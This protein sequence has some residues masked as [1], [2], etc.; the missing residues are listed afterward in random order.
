MI[1]SI[2]LIVSIIVIKFLLDRRLKK[3][4]FN[5]ESTRKKHSELL[6]EYEK[7]N[8]INGKLSQGMQSL[9]ELYEITKE[10]TKHLTFNEVLAVFQERLKKDI[11]LEDCRFLNP[12]R[13]VIQEKGGAEISNGVKPEIDSASLPGY[14][15]FHLKIA[16]D[17]M[18]SF[19]LKGLK[20]EEREKF[21]ILFNQLL[22]V[23]K[24]VRLYEKIEELSIIDSLT[25]LYLRRYLQEKLEE[26]INRCKKFGFNFVFLM[27]D[28]DHFKSYNDRYG[29]LVGD[30]LLSSVA[31]IIKDN[32]R[33]IDIVARYGGEEFS[34][35]LPST[36]R[37][38]AEY[39]SQRLRQEV[40]KSHIRAYDEDLQITISI[41]GSL[42]PQDS[43][44]VND[45]INK[46]DEALYRA[47]QAGRNRVYFFDE[48][49]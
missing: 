35:I 6:K 42:F 8:K 7:L 26:E 27:L 33:Q 49:K 40:E 10:L 30:V 41:G 29:H 14:E 16:E 23:L 9:V 31:K 37:D 25:G 36:S 1:I 43:E 19:A 2:F 32:V 28:L 20:S 11:S 38:E 21:Y 18:G 44:G 24:R 15:I 12:V 3:F 48:Q 4:R 17:L 39:V 13:N 5:Y 45:L 34:I 47:K 46:A 22:L